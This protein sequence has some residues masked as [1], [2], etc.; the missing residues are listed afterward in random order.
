M[1][2]PAAIFENPQYATPVGLVRYA[3]LLDEQRPN[4]GRI[5][6]IGQALGGIFGGG[7]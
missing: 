6:A 4:K 7:R 5:K 1:S 3:Q 2:G